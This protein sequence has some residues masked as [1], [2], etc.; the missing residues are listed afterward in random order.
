MMKKLI[1]TICLLALSMT[2]GCSTIFVDRECARLAKE[3]VIWKTTVLTRKSADLPDVDDVEELE[4]LNQKI[5]EKYIELRYSRDTR[6]S[7]FLP[8]LLHELFAGNKMTVE[9]LEKLEFT[10]DANDFDLAR[11]QFQNVG[12]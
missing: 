5:V 1:M 2:L 12:R 10:L 8:S 7:M 4:K 3:G 9:V 11:K 6:Y